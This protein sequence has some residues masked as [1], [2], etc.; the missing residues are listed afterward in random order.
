MPYEPE[1][2]RKHPLKQVCRRIAGSFSKLCFYTRICF[3]KKSF[4]VHLSL[5][6]KFPAYP[7]WE[8]KN[9]F[10]HFMAKYFR[11]QDTKTQRILKKKS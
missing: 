8:V 6:G 10:M 5:C 2:G 7:G 1:A 9:D 3:K 4:F 11:H